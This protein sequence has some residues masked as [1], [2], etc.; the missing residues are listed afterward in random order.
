M[1]NILSVIY[2]FILA[3]VFLLFPAYS[4]AQVP[5]ID[6][7]DSAGVGIPSEKMMIVPDYPYPD[8]RVQPFTGQNH[9]YSVVLRGNGE[10]VITLKAAL[11]NSNPDGSDLA[12]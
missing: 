9:N 1:K 10:A 7:S 5:R 8:G 12:T 2:G 4:L 11:T 3:L 6:D